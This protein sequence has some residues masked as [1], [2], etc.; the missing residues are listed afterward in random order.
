M[1]QYVITRDKPQLSNTIYLTKED[2]EKSSI[3]YTIS[4]AKHNQEFEMIKLHIIH[5]DAEIMV[6]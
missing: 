4:T 1:G 2:R 3:W 5:I 6:I